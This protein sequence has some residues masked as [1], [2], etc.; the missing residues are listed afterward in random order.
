[1]GPLTINR[2]LRCFRLLHIAVETLEYKIN[3]DCR[4]ESKFYDYLFDYIACGDFSNIFEVD[5]SDFSNVSEEY[6]LFQLM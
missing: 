3:R 5:S 6:R 4:T 2:Y 1:M